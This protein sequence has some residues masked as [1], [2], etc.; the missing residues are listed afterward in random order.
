MEH[1]R[2]NLKLFY[3]FSFFA[4]LQATQVIAWYLEHEAHRNAHSKEKKRHNKIRE[5]HS[6]PRCVVYR[7]K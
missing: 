3:I 6:E 1:R 7:W 4:D 2:M 5:R